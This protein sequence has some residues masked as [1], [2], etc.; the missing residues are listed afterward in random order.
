MVVTATNKVWER[1]ISPKSVFS[2]FK[3]ISVVAET[4]VGIFVR[5]LVYYSF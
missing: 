3:W 2:V 5:C 1:T 4:F